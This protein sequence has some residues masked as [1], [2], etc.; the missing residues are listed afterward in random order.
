MTAAAPIERVELRIRGRVQGVSFRA[1]AREEARRLGLVGWVQ[2]MP[3]G[4]V[5]AVAEGPR[6][7]LERFVAWCHEG[8]PSASVQDVQARYEAAT[9]E[10][11]T[12]DIRRVE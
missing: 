5:Q 6:A 9:G 10:A 4:S 8:S 11:V 2:N 1:Y 7:A 3:D 12:F